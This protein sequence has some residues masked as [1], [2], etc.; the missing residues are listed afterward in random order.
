M[1]ETAKQ[2]QPHVGLLINQIFSSDRRHALLHVLSEPSQML[3]AT[4]SSPVQSV[5]ILLFVSIAG[6]QS[7]ITESKLQLII[8]N[9]QED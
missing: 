8:C 7:E 6:F 9:K 3:T 2:M 5:S 4:A 1:L